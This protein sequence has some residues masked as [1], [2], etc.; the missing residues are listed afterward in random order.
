MIMLNGNVDWDPCKHD[1]LLKDTKDWFNN[2]LDLLLE[3]KTSM[4]L[5]AE[6]G[7]TTVSTM[8]LSRML[9]LC[10]LLTRAS[11]I[12]PSLMLL[13]MISPMAARHYVL[14][15]DCY[16]LMASSSILL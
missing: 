9:K 8:L 7:N 3:E 4:N 2:I 13:L 14:S 16:L 11:M 6:F 15:P 12:H 5:F 10:K 1:H